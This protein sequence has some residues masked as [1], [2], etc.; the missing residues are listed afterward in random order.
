ME[1]WLRKPQNTYK[2]LVRIR[3]LSDRIYSDMMMRGQRLKRS[4]AL[5]TNSQLV[6][7][8]FCV[9]QSATRRYYLYTISMHSL[10]DVEVASLTLRAED[11]RESIIKM[12]VEAGSGHTAGPLGMADVFTA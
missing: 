7:Y 11:I 3:L 8:R 2:K 5:L 9:L 10:T 1:L 4:T 12:L 6:R